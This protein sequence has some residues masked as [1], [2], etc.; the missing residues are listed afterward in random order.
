MTQL[1]GRDMTTLKD[2]D[3]DDLY[4]IFDT[5][6]QMK[7]EWK[8]GQRH[9]IL[10]DRTLAM[11][12]EIP[13]TRTSISFETAMTQLGGHGI[14]LSPG[15]TWIKIEESWRDA[16]RVIDRY[17][18][19]I[20][21]RLMEHSVL[22]QIAEWAKVPVINASDDWEHPCQALTDFF[23]FFERRRRFEGAKW[24]A[25]W[26][27]RESTAPIGLVHSSL[28][29]APRLG[30]DYVIAA[31][32]GYEPD[33]R[34]LE[35]AKKEAEVTGAKIEFVDNLEEAVEGADVINIYSYVAPKYFRMALDAYKKTGK[36]AAPAPHVTDPE[37]YKH[38]K[39]TDE[40]VDRAKRNV[41]VMHCMPVARGEECDDSV[42]DGPRSVMIDEA[43]NRLHVQKAIL[44]L[45][46]GGYPGK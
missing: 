5:A 6:R 9:P 8:R 35:F 16:M 28:Y 25:A 10:Q 27:Y 41:M 46:L 23:T 15:R 21:A 34:V 11:F 20:T 26:G 18:D 2:Y 43:E 12:F 37:K 3:V 36:Y 44:A 14:Y 29:I 32:K 19:G 22:E 40:H 31:P 30:I 39:V 42:V 13:S 7:L 45:L 33:P 24:V 17:V 38:W 1:A 4:M